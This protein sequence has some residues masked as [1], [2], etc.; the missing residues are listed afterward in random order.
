LAV[1]FLLLLAAAV[2]AVV[3]SLQIDVACEHKRW[4]VSRHVTNMSL[5]GLNQ[6]E[7][8]ELDELQAASRLSQAMVV[9]VVV[10]VVVVAAAAAAAVVVVVVVVVR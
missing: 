10:V 7:Y 4:N 9:V 5:P 8:D 3:P 1:W 2:V 6:V